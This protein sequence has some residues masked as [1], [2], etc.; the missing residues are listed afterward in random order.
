MSEAQEAKAERRA[1]QMA[2]ATRPGDDGLWSL[3]D[4]RARTDAGVDVPAGARFRFDGLRDVL[5]AGF[6]GGGSPNERMG[7][8]DFIRSQ[9]ITVPQYQERYG[10]LPLVFNDDGTATFDPAA[11]R[12]AWSYT[13]ANWDR[14]WQIPAVAVAAMTGA[15][16][17]GLGQAA[18]APVAAETA[19]VVVPADFA[20]VPVGSGVGIGGVGTAGVGLGTAGS[21]VGLTPTLATAGGTMLSGGVIGATADAL[22]AAA[23]AGALSSI[24][25]TAQLASGMGAAATV[26]A[27]TLPNPKTIADAARA[28]SAVTSAARAIAGPGA[29]PSRDLLAAP[30][31]SASPFFVNVGEPI[32]ATAP[33]A[34]ATQPVKAPAFGADLQALL[35]VVVVAVAVLYFMQGDGK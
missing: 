8:E 11:Q 16:L 35:P 24:P 9:G 26:A 4:L 2:L 31:P 17:A 32:M 5:D 27:P 19:A 6:V 13:P 3:A 18:A 22:A 23:G 10:G 21:A 14:Y 28:A 20:L 34:A 33:K 25:V 15:H 12:N 29:A 7:V 30:R 1:R